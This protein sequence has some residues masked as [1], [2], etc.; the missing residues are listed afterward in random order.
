M[1]TYQLPKT[2]KPHAVAAKCLMTIKPSTH[3]RLRQCPVRLAEF[4]Q[5]MRL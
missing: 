1:L 3:K 5:I 4:I 2:G